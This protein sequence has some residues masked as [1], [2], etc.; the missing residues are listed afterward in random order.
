MSRPPKIGASMVPKELNAC[1]RFNRLEAVSGLPITATYGLAA[2]WSRVM[3]EAR[4]NSATR[5]K[6]YETV[7]AAGTKATALTA[8]PTRPSTT[9]SL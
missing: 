6:P 8:M 4:R 3:E 2:T 9:E 7:M 5:K 1:T